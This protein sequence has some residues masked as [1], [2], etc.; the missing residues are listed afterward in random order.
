MKR[1]NYN[2]LADGRQDIQFKHGNAV[3]TGHG[4]FN[5][6]KVWFHASAGL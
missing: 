3:L 1:E 2:T 4:D 6:R 5:Q